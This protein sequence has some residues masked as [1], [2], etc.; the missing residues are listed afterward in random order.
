MSGN[1]QK[2]TTNLTIGS[3]CPIVVSP[4]DAI[5]NYATA[6]TIART[7]DVQSGLNVCKPDLYDFNQVY[8]TEKAGTCC[9]NVG[10]K[11]TFY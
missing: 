9:G 1:V 6:S 10:P 11:T 8:A 2:I 7:S 3:I 4:Q 5:V